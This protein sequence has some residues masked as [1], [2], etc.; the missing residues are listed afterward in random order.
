MLLSRPRI[1]LA[2][3]TLITLALLVYTIG[4][5]YEMGG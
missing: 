1:A 3:L 2:I 4:A 5:P